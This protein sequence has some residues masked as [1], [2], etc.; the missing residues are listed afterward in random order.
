MINEGF[1]VFLAHNPTA[2]DFAEYVKLFV[3]LSQD[4]LFIYFSGRARH[5]GIKGKR[6][7]DRT[8][9]GKKMTPEQWSKEEWQDQ[10]LC[11]KDGAI[12]DD[13]LRLVLLAA[14]KKKLPTLKITL[15]QDCSYG[16]SVWDIDF[17]PET[18]PDKI[19]SISPSSDFGQLMKVHT[20]GTTRSMFTDVFVNTLIECK[21]RRDVTIG[22]IGGFVE[23]KWEDMGASECVYIEASRPRLCDVMLH[24][25]MGW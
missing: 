1:R 6:I 16:Q 5:F 14:C 24:E 15:V 21:K 23:E 9:T 25:W 19:V 20:M 2:K 8:F 4:L 10:A 22:G 7:L 3:R 13:T 11:F 18:L 17:K 12:R